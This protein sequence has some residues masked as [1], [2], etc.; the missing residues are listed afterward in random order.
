MVMQV[1]LT[2]VLPAHSAT[3]V[4]A[5]VVLLPLPLQLVDSAED[6][7]VQ[8]LLR[9]ADVEEEATNFPFIFE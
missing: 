1:V 6:L 8:A 2:V 9:A 7:E 5:W 3:A 4:P